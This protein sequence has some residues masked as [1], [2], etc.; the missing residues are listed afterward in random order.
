MN[1]LSRISKVVAI[2]SPLALA[3]CGGGDAAPEEDGAGGEEIRVEFE[4]IDESAAEGQLT[5][6]PTDG[7]F[8]AVVAIDTHRGPG[9]YPVHILQGTC[10]EG[11]SIVVSLNSVTGQEGGEGQSSTTFPA[12]DLPPGQ[13][14]VQLHDAQDNAPLACADLPPME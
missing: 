2:W 8:T 12:A 9:D 1:T 11:G 7:S 13:Y 4:E 10:A 14:F 6:T 5:L 3:S